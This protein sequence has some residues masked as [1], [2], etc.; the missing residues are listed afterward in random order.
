MLK[1][2][3]KEIAEAR[4]DIASC[5][6]ELQQAKRIRKNRQEYDAL[7]RVIETHPDRKK[8]QAETNELE[9][10]IS[11]LE[12]IKN[13]LARKLDLRAKQLHA[14]IHSVHVLQQILQEDDDVPVFGQQTTDN[15]MDTS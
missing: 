13:S 5:K 3:E 1:E 14:L 6:I 2:I 8:S 12:E 15:S 4:K 11:K 7:A 10:E 9:Q